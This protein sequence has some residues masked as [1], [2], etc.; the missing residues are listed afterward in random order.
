MQAPLPRPFP[1]GSAVPQ[2]LLLLLASSLV[3]AQAATRVSIRDG[4][5]FLNDQVTH[6]RSPAE[7]RLMNVRMVNCTFEDRR[8]TDFDPA[9]NTDR[10]LAQLPAY[11]AQGVRAFTLNLQGG[12]PGYEDALNS[13]FHPDG[14]LLPEYFARVRRVIEAC[15]RAGLAVIL[16]CFYQ[17]QDQ[18]LEDEAAVRAALVNTVRWI[19]AAGFRNVVLE[20]ANEFDHGGFDHPVL[21]TAGGQLELI[22]LAHET[23]PGLLV[24]TS[25]LGHGRYPEALAQ[26]ADFLLIHF[27]GT[28]VKDI[29]A[30]I[31]ALLPFG[32]PVVCNEDDKLGEEAAAAARAAVEAGGSWGFMH[33][34]RN[35]Y[36]PFEFLGPE[37]DPVVYAA[38]RELTSPA[39]RAAPARGP[40]RVHP[41]NPRYLADDL[42]RAVLL[43]GSHTWNNLQDMLPPEG[44]APFDYP[45]WLGFLQAHDHNFMRLWR[46]ELLT[47]DTAANRQQ[48]PVVLAATPHPWPRTGPGK[49]LDG[50]PRFDLSRFNEAYFDRLRECVALAAESGIYTAVMLFEGW[51]LQFVENAWQAHP[52]HPDNNINGID[53]D[54]E[55]DGR[56]LEIHQL[57]HPAV[58]TL[59]E[60]YVRQ[61]IDTLNDLDNV[62]YEIS[63][64]NHPASTDWQYHF[65]RFIHDNERTKPKQHLVGMTFQYKGGR[66]ET[67]FDSP[68]DWISPNPSAPDGFNH[69]DN[70]PP[71]DGS[72]VVISDTDHLWGLGG[73]VAWVWKTFLRGAHPIFMDP[74]DGAVL[75]RGGDDQWEPVRRAMGA[76]ARVAASLDLAAMHPRLDFGPASF[77]LA[78]DAGTRLAWLPSGTTLRLEPSPSGRSVEVQWFHPETAAPESPAATAIVPPEAPALRSPFEGEAIVLIRPH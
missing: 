57:G 62:L 14:S 19:Q 44:G 78:D 18:I 72:K 61:V 29:P 69:R 37:D 9:A 17:R 39:L 68:A 30:R 76:V 31:G 55:G 48:T 25:G 63:N 33:K 67:L 13:A 22:R 42:G 64:E 49:A 6:P 53:G 35:Q 2:L 26:A 45:A 1:P 21:R 27:N 3:A 58:L 5:W 38:F 24:S 50:Q 60:A 12:M 4:R 16:G 54:R 28:P 34:T 52:F 36:Q 77:C 66:N 74:Y 11:A 51:G 73:N 15:D 8:R 56:G 41:R 46:W 70:P 40:L 23:L 75:R 7:G 10:F 32:K 47:W 71:A 20:I 59:Q 65:I 43:T